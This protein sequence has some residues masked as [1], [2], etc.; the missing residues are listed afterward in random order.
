MDA[1]VAG[2]GG[3]IDAHDVTLDA[4]LAGTT[5][6]FVTAV[7]ALAPGRS[8]STARRRC[9]A[10]RWARCTT[11]SPQ[12]GAA[13]EPG[14]RAGGLPV[15]VGGPLRDGGDLASPATSPAST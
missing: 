12:L 11:P 7:A 5:S 3:R 10:G 14:E 1:V 6:R 15:T 4:G 13:V 2:R 8:R 9:G